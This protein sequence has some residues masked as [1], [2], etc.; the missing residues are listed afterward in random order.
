MYDALANALRAGEVTLHSAET[1]HQLAS[2][3]GSTLKAPEGQHDDRA[4]AFALAVAG[5]LR[6]LRQA[7]VVSSAPV[8]LTAGRSS[9]YEQPLSYGSNRRVSACGF[10][11][12]VNQLASFGSV[13]DFLDLPPNIDPQLFIE[14]RKWQ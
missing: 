8:I 7:G 4:V 3:E 10:G 9:P 14:A 11:A 2:I 6:L 5:R 13:D 12:E 1:F